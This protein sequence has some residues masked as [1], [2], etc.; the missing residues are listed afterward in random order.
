MFTGSTAESSEID[1]NGMRSPM[2]L[3]IINIG[4]KDDSE[5]NLEVKFQSKYRELEQELCKLREVINNEILLSRDFEKGLAEDVFKLKKSINNRESI[6]QVSEVIALLRTENTRLKDR[7]NN[8]MNI[9]SGLNK[10]L[11]IVEEEKKELNYSSANTTR[12]RR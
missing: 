7:E 2:P 1:S 6:Y 10:K 3:G 12:K 9:I 4:S 11:E 8:L 5:V